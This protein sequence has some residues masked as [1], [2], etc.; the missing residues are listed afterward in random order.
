MAVVI[1]YKTEGAFVD[2]GMA[3]IQ[4]FRAFRLGGDQGHGSEFD[5]LHHL[6]G[7]RRPLVERHGL[8]TGI[9]KYRDHFLFLPPESS[10]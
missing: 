2:H 8:K 1:P 6:P 5:A 9:Q 10:A 7:F 3:L 4:A